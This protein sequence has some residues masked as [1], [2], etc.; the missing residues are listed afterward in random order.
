LFLLIVPTDRKQPITNPH[1]SE[2]PAR[3]CV[4]SFELKGLDLLVFHD[5]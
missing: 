5:K 3:S 2:A 1:F 4:S